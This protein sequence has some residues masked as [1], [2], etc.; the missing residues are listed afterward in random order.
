MRGS[1]PGVHSSPNAAPD[2]GD[3]KSSSRS[4]SC[5]SATPTWDGAHD[6]L[7]DCVRIAQASVR[8]GEGAPKRSIIWTAT[9]SQQLAARRAHCASHLHEARVDEPS[10]HVMEVTGEHGIH[11]VADE[12]VL[13]RTP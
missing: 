9:V 11:D 13:R 6:P 7:Q 4:A 3:V 1:A 10:N 8:H 2:M 12:V 5:R